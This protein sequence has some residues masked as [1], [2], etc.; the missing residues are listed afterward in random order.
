MLDADVVA[1]SPS[2]VYRVL[3]SAGRIGQQ[4]HA[5][6]TKGQGFDQ[7]N[8]PHAHWHMDISYLNICGTF[9]YLCTI[10]DGYSRYIVHWEIRESMTEADVE[11][12]LQRGR[13]AFPGVTPRIISDNG[14]Q[15][16]ARDFKEFV[17]LCGMTHVRTSPYYP[18]SNGKIESWHKTVKRE[19][20]R[21]L[22]PLNLEDARR[23]VA[24][25][26]R[27][28]NTVRLHSGIGYV[29]PLA[30]LEG[31]DQKIIEG[32]R[33]KLAAAREAR[34]LAHRQP[35]PEQQVALQAVA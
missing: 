28:Y 26:V 32:R 9:Y 35:Q 1:A 14:P 22:T 4:S 13:E 5:P 20:I 15:F 23:I 8:Q 24:K 34:R 30:R 19:C 29:T 17:R 33:T 16:V 7:P 31:R 6:S 10:L 12:V 2:S 25:Y 21:P 11:I 27:E 3:K 18:Q